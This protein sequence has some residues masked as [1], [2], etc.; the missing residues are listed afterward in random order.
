MAIST[1]PNTIRF[2]LSTAPTASAPESLYFPYPVRDDSHLDVYREGVLQTITTHYTVTLDSDLN[3]ATV[4]MI[5]GS[6]SDD[7]VVQRKIPLTQLTAYIE[8][9]Q[10]PAK[11]HEL[12]LDYARMV[13]QQQE[14]EITGAVRAPAHEDPQQSML[15]PA[16]A[17]RVNTVSTYGAS[18]E[19][20]VSNRDQ[21]LTLLGLSVNNPSTEKPQQTFLNDAAR[22]AAT[23][24]FIGQLGVQV[25]ATATGRPP[26]TLFRANSTSV[27]DWDD[28][29]LKER[30][31]QFE[32]R[33]VSKTYGDDTYDGKTWKSAKKTLPAAIETLPGWDPNA[34][35]PLYAARGRVY[36]D[37][38]FYNLDEPLRYNSGPIKWISSVTVADPAIWTS[39]AH[40]F[41][42]NDAV[43][44][45]RFYNDDG[46]VGRVTITGGTSNPGTN[47]VDS[48]TVSDWAGNATEILSGNVDHTGDN[49]TT[50]AAVVANINAHESVPNYTAVANGAN[51]E[52]HQDDGAEAHWNPIA[53]TG[54][55]D[56]TGTTVRMTSWYPHCDNKEG[57]AP[58]NNLGIVENFTYYV[59]RIDAD[60][61]YL[62][63][64]TNGGTANP[65]SDTAERI[66]I[67]DGPGAT[68]WSTS[69][70]NGTPMLG[71]ASNTGG[72]ALQLIGTSQMQS[73]QV[74]IRNSVGGPVWDLD[75]PDS[76]SGHGFLAVN[77]RFSVSG[78]G[79]TQRG[80]AGI[81]DAYGLAHRFDRR[82]EINPCII[83]EGGFHSR[84]LDCQFENGLCGM[85]ITGSTNVEV[86]RPGFGGHGNKNGFLEEGAAMPGVETSS[87]RGG[88]IKMRSGA[89]AILNVFS[90][91]IDACPQ[92][93][94]IIC[95]SSS[96]VNWF[97][98][99]F[100]RS[101]NK[102]QDTWHGFALARI[103]GKG[104]NISSPLRGQIHGI[105]MTGIH[106]QKSTHTFDTLT[107]D[108][109]NDQWTVPNSS[110]T[111]KVDLAENA[112]E[113]ASGGPAH[114]F[115]WDDRILFAVNDPTGAADLSRVYYVVQPDAPDNTG[116]SA[117]ATHFRISLTKNGTALTLIDPGGNVTV[118]RAL[119]VVTGQSVRFTS[120][121]MPTFSDAGPAINTTTTYYAIK[122]NDWT[123]QIARSRANADAGTEIT[124]SAMGANNG[125]GYGQGNHHRHLFFQDE[126]EDVAAYASNI[127]STGPSRWVLATDI[128]QERPHTFWNR[129]S[130]TRIVTPKATWSETG[131]P[132][133]PGLFTVNPVQVKLPLHEADWKAGAGQYAEDEAASATS[134]AGNASGTYHFYGD[135]G[136]FV[137]YQREKDQAVERDVTGA[138]GTL[139]LT[140]EEI[141]A[142]MI[143]LRCTGNATVTG[144]Q[145][146]GLPSMGNT[147]T[148]EWFRL[149]VVNTTTPAD[150]FTVTLT[151]GGEGDNLCF[152]PAGNHVLSPGETVELIYMNRHSVTPNTEMG[153]LKIGE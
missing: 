84:F 117:S 134:P 66:A 54:A 112:L 43:H 57:S 65:T 46:A 151:N 71:V 141:Y 107:S 119:P 55:G 61:F 47:Y 44:F 137:R 96:N 50:A 29:E 30:A 16:A 5:A 12:A 56:V 109:A 39:T 133:Q 94:D 21:M 6:L 8:T 92:L 9:G 27:G 52:I 129:T 144:F 118:R 22:A 80:D 150:A 93:L 33:Y 87:P 68:T 115:E 1:E 34:V 104:Q 37:S 11:V 105:N 116:S 153:W 67:L 10:F 19:A 113:R 95:N 110:Q 36:L 58:P 17:S 3:G 2:T 146:D 49:S 88:G 4:N 35:T 31:L 123:M 122:V 91:Q 89:A 42:T 103:N 13:D 74:V 59:E 28:V 24:N 64:D 81:A 128:V 140:D 41:S 99:K 125:F 23:P 26:G 90:P 51:V 72:G 148:A 86:M 106:F 20:T 131:S 14:R 138:L 143:L 79:S 40:G 120:G 135:Y 32:E 139:T 114:E 145:A 101:E 152:I 126:G 149:L 78:N 76:A 85:Y 83:L 48:I 73:D 62:H 136:G 82:D 7:V 108:N 127:T 18:G 121:T 15:L 142:G 147:N 53:F 97:G 130:G 69:Y 98:G 25:N 38:G 60:T 102:A 70:A 132:Q 75:S 111:M 77:I 124:F 100:E 63:N 45:K